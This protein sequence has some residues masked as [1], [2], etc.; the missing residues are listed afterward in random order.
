[1]SLSYHLSF[2]SSLCL[3]FFTIVKYHI[4]N[5]CSWL[6]LKR[7]TSFGVMKELIYGEMEM[8]EALK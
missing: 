4:N 3:I 5:I 6:E 2:S 7:I 8:D 1:M